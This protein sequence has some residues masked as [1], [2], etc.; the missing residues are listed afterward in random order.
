MYNGQA[1]KIRDNLVKNIKNRF[2][3]GTNQ[4]KE[5]SCPNDFLSR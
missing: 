3:S 1:Y 2:K 4:K 5:D